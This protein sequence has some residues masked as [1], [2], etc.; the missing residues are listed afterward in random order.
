MLCIF[1]C[2]SAV[3]MFFFMPES[4]TFLYTKRRYAT[5]SK[6][7]K[8]VQICRGNK[9][10]VEMHTKIT[11]VSDTDSDLPT[12]TNILLTKAKVLVSS[13]VELFFPC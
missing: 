12:T 10:D 8:T 7:L 13:T 4:P 3:L 1:P 9:T 11:D 5:L 6:A 2:L